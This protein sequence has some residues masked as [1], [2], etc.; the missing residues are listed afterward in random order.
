ML[1]RWVKEEWHAAHK[2]NTSARWLAWRL[3]WVVSEQAVWRGRAVAGELTTAIWNS[4][5]ILTFPLTDRHYIKPMIINL[6]AD[7]DRPCSSS[8]YCPPS[9]LSHTQSFTSAPT[10]T[11]TPSP[12]PGVHMRKESGASG[13]GHPVGAIE[14]HG[15]G[16]AET[17]DGAGQ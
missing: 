3:D 12:S 8:C 16:G 6:T 10:P 13:E 15:G 1:T 2:V 17:A 14:C 4:V 11:P 9:V 7:L 5:Y